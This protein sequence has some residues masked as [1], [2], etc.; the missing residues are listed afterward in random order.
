MAGLNFQTQTIINSNFD[1]DSNATLFDAGSGV[2]NIKRDFHFYADKEGV[3]KVKAI[4]KRAGYEAEMCKATIDFSKFLDKIQDTANNTYCRLDLYVGLEGN[5]ELLYASPSQ[6]LP[7]I[8]FWIEFTVK[9]SDTAIT[10]AKNVAS[11]I[12]TNHVFQR[13]KD[14][15]VVTDPGDGTLVLTG[16][17]EYQRFKKMSVSKAV[18]EYADAVVTLGEDGITLNTIGKNSFGTYSQIVKDL[19]LPTIN[20]AYPLRKVEAPIIGAVYNEYIL[21]YVG[22]ANNGGFQFVGQEGETNTT[23]VFWV[24]ND[25]ALITEW[26]TALGTVGT[27]TDVDA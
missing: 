7:G 21:E 16:A 27:I 2:L 8:P 14:L 15:V 6:V 9:P 24:K 4:R 20:T 11:A 17:T 23:H 13:D 26:E 10:V 12:K 25:A 3:G 22:P 5:M 18:D 19:R 1:P